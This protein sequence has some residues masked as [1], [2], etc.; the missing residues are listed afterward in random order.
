MFMGT[1]WFVFMYYGWAFFLDCCLWCFVFSL[2]FW[3]WLLVDCC[4]LI[5]FNSY[6][7]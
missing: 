3:L 1:L 7:E 5:I 6:L 4:I 2:C